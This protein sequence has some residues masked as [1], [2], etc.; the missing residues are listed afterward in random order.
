M[1][2]RSA[3]PLASGKS[4]P[5]LACD[6]RAVALAVAWLALAPVAP[7]EAACANP[8][9]GARARTLSE[10]DARISRLAVSTEEKLLVGLDRVVT[11]RDLEAALDCLGPALA[12]QAQR[13]PEQH[14][15][16]GGW[17]T[18]GLI[19]HFPGNEFAYGR[20]F[21]NEQAREY[22]AGQVAALPGATIVKEAFRFSGDGTAHLH[23]IALMTLATNGEGAWSWLKADA[24]GKLHQESTPCLACHNWKAATGHQFG[25][26]FFASRA[27]EIAGRK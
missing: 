1:S 17:R 27:R 16:Y 19:H 18:D 3:R 6:G 12:Q 5:R 14:G 22:L 15:L 13:L 9:L 8:G 26:S 24:G 10:N 25:Y 7:V 11:L 20:I 4:G 21:V 23:E 2:W